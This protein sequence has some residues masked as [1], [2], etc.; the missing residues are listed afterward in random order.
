ME[1]QIKTNCPYGHYGVP[2]IMGFIFYFY[3]FQQPCPDCI[4]GQRPDDKGI[5]VLPG[6]GYGSWQY[7]IWGADHVS[8]AQYS[9]SK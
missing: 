2:P 6:R 3:F 4:L 9:F 1:G 7:R 5:L 8:G